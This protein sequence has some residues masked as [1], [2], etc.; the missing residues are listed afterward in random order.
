MVN[1]LNIGKIAHKSWPL[2]IKVSCASKHNIYK[3]KPWS[4][5][6]QRFEEFKM[7]HLLF[8]IPYKRSVNWY[9]KWKEVRAFM[10]VPFGYIIL[11]IYSI[12]TRTYSSCCC[13][14]ESSDIS[15]HIWLNSLDIQFIFISRVTFQWIQMDIHLVPPPW[16]LI[17]K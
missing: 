5:W 6:P 17:P 1:W 4:L 11:T 15:L 16:W 13:L 14:F 12:F 7:N 9:L 3:L 8:I 2:T 10:G